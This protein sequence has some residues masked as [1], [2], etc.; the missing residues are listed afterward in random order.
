MLSG[1]TTSF[2]PGRTGLIGV[3]GS[4]K[5]TLLKL[6][7]GELRPVRGPGRAAAIQRQGPS[8]RPSSYK[9]AATPTTTPTP[10]EKAKPLLGTA[11]PARRAA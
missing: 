9:G 2:G 7:A 3:N 4:G 1:L 8:R 10:T 5:S 11:A 6:I